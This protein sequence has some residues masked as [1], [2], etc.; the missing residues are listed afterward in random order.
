MYEAG[1]VI[2]CGVVGQINGRH[3][4]VTRIDMRQRMAKV[5][6]CERFSGRYSDD[7]ADELVALHAFVHEAFRQYQQATLRVDQGVWQVRVEV[8]RLIGGNGPCGS[9]PDH[10]ERGFFQRIQAESGC[11]PLGLCAQKSNIQSLRLFVRIL[12]FEFGQRGSA[13]EAPVHRLQT[14]V[15]KPSF[16]HAFERTDLLSL[17]LEV[18]RAV[19][20]VPFTQYPQPLEVCHLDA[21]LLGR[22]SAALC[23]HLVA[24]QIAAKLLLNSVFYRQTVAIPTGDI[25]CVE[26]FKLTLLDDHVLKYF[27]YGM[28]HVDLT[29]GVRWAVVQDELW[30]IRPRIAKRFIY[31]FFVPVLGPAGLS[32]W[33][34]AAHRERGLWQIKGAAVISFFSHAM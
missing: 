22:E 14:S 7:R 24:G 28:A 10:G 18:H 11:K 15:H 29:I 16:D 4:V 25:P 2:G 32:L 8:K 31:A 20:M 6:S 27:V 33:Q 5:N 17:I 30:S 1:S 13:I 21:D 12:N 34:V 23:L 9:G 3:T 26:P 19:R